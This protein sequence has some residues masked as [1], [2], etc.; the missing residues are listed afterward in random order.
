MPRT[1][2]VECPGCPPLRALTTDV[3]GL[4][5][6]VEARGKT[7]IPKVVET[8]GQP[9]AS[10]CVL[11]ASYSDRKT[12]PL[13][14][15]ARKNGL[16]LYKFHVEFLNPPNGEALGITKIDQFRS[17]DSSLQD[18]H[19]LVVISNCMHIHICSILY[20]FQV[21]CITTWNMC[22][23]GKRLCTLPI[24]FGDAAQNLS[25]FS[26]T[27]WNVCSAGKIL[28]TSV[29]RSKNFALFGGKD[30]ELNLWDLENCSKIWTAEPPPS[31]SLCI[32]YP[33]WLTTATFLSE[34]DH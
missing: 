17:L 31:N 18:D 4:V 2:A 33:T 26:R 29:D 5:K 27:T 9:D 24:S 13:L 34:D 12:D 10:S 32:F 23:A 8:W 21:G 20:V 19:I 7:G 16:I 3:L 14:A 25:M 30:V 28:S 1:S 15:V 6:V 11:A 22:S